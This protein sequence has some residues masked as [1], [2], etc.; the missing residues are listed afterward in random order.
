MKGGR[1]RGSGEGRTLEHGREIRRIA[2]AVGK[3]GDVDIDAG[4]S[5]GVFRPNAWRELVNVGHTTRIRHLNILERRRHDVVAGVQLL[6]G[7]CPCTDPA[8]P[9]SPP[10]PPRPPLPP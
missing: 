2:A 5:A 10:P 7:F 4:L 9:H 6:Y 3:P 1:E 8:F